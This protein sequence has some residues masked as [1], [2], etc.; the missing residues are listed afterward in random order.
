MLDLLYHIAMAFGLMSL[1]ITAVLLALSAI[2][3]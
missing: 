1:A 2:R 3:P